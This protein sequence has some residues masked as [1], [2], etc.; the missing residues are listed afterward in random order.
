MVGAQMLIW[1][2]TSILNVTMTTLADPKAGLGATPA[3]A[4]WAASAY[5][6]VL[7]GSLL[8]SGALADRFGP[9]TTLVAGLLVF[10]TSSAAGAFAGTPGQLIA[11]RSVMGAGSALFMPATLSIIMQCTPATHRTRAIA[12]WSGS[13]GLG[14]AVGPFAGGMLLSHFW[15]GAVFLVNVPLVALCLGGMAAVVPKLPGSGRRVLDLPGMAL[16][17][18]GLSSLVFGVI[19]VGQREHWYDPRVVLPLLA[20]IMLLVAFVDVQRR[21]AAPSLDLRLFSLAGFPAGSAVLLLTFMGL[22]G[23]LFYVAFY[24]QGPR[25][26]SPAT[27]GTVM[28]AAAGGVV[29]GSQVSPGLSQRLSARWTVVAGLSAASVTYLAY[30]LFDARTPLLVIVV[31]LWV[32]G[33][34]IGLVG[35]PVTAAMMTGVPGHLMGTGS[36]V[37]GVTRQV[38]STLGVAVIGAVL[39][40]G[41]REEMASALS[42]LPG[43]SPHDQEQAQA[44]AEAARALAGTLGRP[45][46]AE[47][48]DRT[49]LT[50]MDTA[51]SWTAVLALVGLSVAAAGLGH[52]HPAR[53]RA[54]AR[55]RPPGRHRAPGRARIVPRPSLTRTAATRTR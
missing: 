1:L 24:L 39:A 34:G 32:Q 28:V 3:E 33:F 22:A 54:L 43:L 41:Y 9:R 5:T 31:V 46:L 35:T 20:G 53:H 50:A 18:L 12:I 42:G 52:R 17:V 36:A 8:A 26:L 51:T 25:G 23:H 19:E 2:D 27:A 14:A 45:E 11:A 40:G 47:A 49:F 13:S 30:L 21:S 37:N 38:G 55:H 4:E 48:A 44:S 10:A 6:L 29:L 16:S 7:A 15:W